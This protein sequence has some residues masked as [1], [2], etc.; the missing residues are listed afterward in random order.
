[1]MRMRRFALATLLALCGCLPG[2]VRLSV[3]AAADVNNRQP[4]YMLVR[5]LPHKTYLAESYSEVAAKLLEMDA[6]VLRKEL[7]LP[8]H[9]Y[10]LYVKQPKTPLAVYFL[11]TEP[12]GSWRLIVDPPFPWQLKTDL[13]GNILLQTAPAF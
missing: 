11:F 5:T 3:N 13:R 2:Y 7:L 8:G 1:M 6:S 9:A 4:L 12:G 10:T